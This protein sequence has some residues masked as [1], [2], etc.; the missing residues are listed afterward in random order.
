MAKATCGFRRSS[1]YSGPRPRREQEPQQASS[2]A[3]P[4]V[5]RRDVG[6]LVVVERQ[7]ADIAAGDNRCQLVKSRISRSVLRMMRLSLL[8]LLF[9]RDGETFPQLDAVLCCVAPGRNRSARC[10]A[11][12]RSSRMRRITPLAHDGFGRQPKGCA[13]TMLTNPF[14]ISSIISPG[15]SQ[16]S[17]IL[18]PSP[19]T[20]GRQPPRFRQNRRNR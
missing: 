4:E 12:L 15:S 17:P 6:Y 11:S 20:S 2:T 5:Q 8:V 16:P 19:M 3:S 9:T 14:S 1:S 13:Q 18:Q 7:P 10:S